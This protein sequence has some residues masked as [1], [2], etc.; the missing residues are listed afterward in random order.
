MDASGGQQNLNFSYND[1]GTPANKIQFTEPGGIILQESI[2]LQDE[3]RIGGAT[4]SADRWIID[5]AGDD[6]FRISF[7]DD[8]ASTTT[9]QLTLGSTGGN[10]TVNQNLLMGVGAQVRI[11]A[12][13]TTADQWRFDGGNSDDTLRIQYDDDD[14]SLS[15]L[16]A[17][18]PSTGVLTYGSD[19]S[20]SYGDRA[21]VDKAYV[22]T[23]AAFQEPIMVVG[24]DSAITA[25]T[26]EQDITISS[27]PI[28]GA[29]NAYSVLLGANTITFDE[30]DGSEIYEVQYNARFDINTA[31]GD[32]RS[33]A[34]IKA[35]LDGVDVANSE[36][37]AYIREF[38]GSTNGV[39]NTGMSHS[40]LIQPADAD[41]LTFRF[42][43]TTDGGTITDFDL[44]FFSVII[45]RIG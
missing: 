26:T 21:I 28:D 4:D 43:G 41:V 42:W 38:Q 6:D 7:Y 19:A 37:W 20:S 31:G 12:G 1:N 36:M 13:L 22:D 10:L 45:K 27:V 5:T 14:G 11:T 8:S 33:Y 24:P 3:V 29:I 30:A 39:P 18:D 17:I 35:R 2:D 16:F 44:A 25:T 9:A 23:K 32:T 15:N 40:F 34:R